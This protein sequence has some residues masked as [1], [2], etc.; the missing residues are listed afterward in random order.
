MGG[1]PLSLDECLAEKGAK[2][3]TRLYSSEEIVANERVIKDRNIAPEPLP[4]DDIRFVFS[5]CE[6]TKDASSL[7]QESSVA[8]MPKHFAHRFKC[9]PKSRIEAGFGPISA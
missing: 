3:V 5:V 2:M 4:S 7:I 8:P 1:E 6:E 9:S